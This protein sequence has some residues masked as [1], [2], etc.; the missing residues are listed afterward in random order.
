MR[1]EELWPPVEGAGFVEGL[2]VYGRS[3]KWREQ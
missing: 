1:L 2:E 3:V